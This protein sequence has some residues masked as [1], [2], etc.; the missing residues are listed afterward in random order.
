MGDDFK[1][2]KI[3]LN[4]VVHQYDTVMKLQWTER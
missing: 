4:E 1:A 3:W 2:K